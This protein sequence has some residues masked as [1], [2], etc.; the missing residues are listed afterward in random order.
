MAVVARG[1]SVRR[2]LSR[3]EASFVALALVVAIG[4]GFVAGR[5]T[6]AP[7]AAVTGRSHPIH[8]VAPL[9]TADGVRRADVMRKMGSFSAGT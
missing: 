7:R 6:S 9:R 3:M 8:L 1:V 2:G 5:A 4:I